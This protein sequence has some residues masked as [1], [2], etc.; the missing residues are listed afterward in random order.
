V[1]SLHAIFFVAL[2]NQMKMLIV[3]FSFLQFGT[4]DYT[5]KN[6]YRY[7]SKDRRFIKNVVKMHGK[8]VPSVITKR[9][10]VITIEYTDTKYTLTPDGWMGETFI[11]EKGSSEWLSLG[12]EL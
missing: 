7:S 1:L 9:N 6:D 10:G 5:I 12:T 11:K 4:P 2:L 8:D 3:I